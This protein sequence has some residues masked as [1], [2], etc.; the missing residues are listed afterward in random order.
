MGKRFL[1]YINGI[2]KP[3][4][5]TDKN[6]HRSVE[7][8]VK[9]ISEFITNSPIVYF[10]NESDGILLRSSEI[11][12]MCVTNIEKNLKRKEVKEIDFSDVDDN[13]SNDIDLLDE[14][15]EI[16][17]TKEVVLE[18]LESEE[19]TEEIEDLLDEETLKEL[20]DVSE[21]DNLYTEAPKPNV[22]NT[23]PKTRVVRRDQ[24]R[25]IDKLPG[26]VPVKR[27]PMPPTVRT[28]SVSPSSG[29][30]EQHNVSE[31]PVRKRNM[32]R[33]I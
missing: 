17:K 18:D 2:A 27:M 19:E 23:T 1:F 14:I 10:S 21:E 29:A 8:L 15:P 4:T 9:E 20:E 26:V 3:I 22:V 16:T 12:G 7:E 24:K 28:E 25:D 31:A 13:K 6:E 33:L 32:G 5:I 30:I 11:S